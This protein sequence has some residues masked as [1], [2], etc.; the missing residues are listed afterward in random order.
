[1]SLQQDLATAQESLVSTEQDVIAAQ[2]EIQLRDDQIKLRNSEIKLRDERIRSREKEIKLRDDQIRKLQSEIHSLKLHIEKQEVTIKTQSRTI[3]DPRSLRQRRMEETAAQGATTQPWSPQNV[4]ISP[5]QSLSLGGP[6]QF[7]ANNSDNGQYFLPHGHP[8]PQMPYQMFYLV[9]PT[10]PPMCTQ[11]ELNGTIA[12]ARLQ[13]LFHP[14]TPMAGPSQ[15]NMNP[16]STMHQATYYAPGGISN[17]NVQGATAYA[18]IE[19]ETKAAEIGGR[20]RSL[21]AKIEQFGSIYVVNDELHPENIPAPLKE[22]MM[23]D[24]NTAVAVQYLNHA[25]TKPMCVAKVINFYLCKKMLKYTEIIKNLS[26]S[27]DG[28]ILSAKRRMNL[29]ASDPL[30]LL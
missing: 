9:E 17:S 3:Q 28:E 8:N 16:Q 25:M 29:G 11:F 22:Y 12:G 23:L 30:P 24:P 4:L 2:E 5:T 21:W 1:M 19:F 15:M 7:A 6:Q 18:G 27:I 20:F 10:A 13:G 14:T 26:P